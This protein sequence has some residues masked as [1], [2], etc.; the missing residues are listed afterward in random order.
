[1]KDNVVLLNFFCGELVD[2]VFV[3][4]VLDDGFLCLYIIDFV[5]KELLNYKKVYVFFYLGVL[6]EEVEIN[7]V[8]MVVKEL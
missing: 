3:K 2:L 7:C 5:I 8:K 6:M 1:M 4:E